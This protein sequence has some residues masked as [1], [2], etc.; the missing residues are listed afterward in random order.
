VSGW[1][2]APT[3]RQGLDSFSGREE[4]L[5][6]SRSS[7]RGPVTESTAR[8][9]RI[10][11]F[12]L[13]Q[14]REF[15]QASVLKV[16][17]RGEPLLKLVDAIGRRQQPAL[18]PIGLKPRR[19]TFRAMSMA[20][21]VELGCQANRR[22]QVLAIELA[23]C[24]ILDNDCPQLSNFGASV[25]SVGVDPHQVNRQRVDLGGQDRSRTN[26]F[27]GLDARRYNET[28]HTGRLGARRLEFALESRDLRREA[29]DGF[30]E[31][32]RFEP[33]PGGLGCLDRHLEFRG[34][35][36]PIRGNDRKVNGHALVSGRTA[37]AL[38][39][40]IGH[41]DGFRIEGNRHMKLSAIVNRS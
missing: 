23:P 26:R 18:V 10:V 9:K 20:E 39:G 17:I 14:V 19:V 5:L 38:F 12:F 32:Q 11:D 16:S 21:L 4:F 35:G 6:K 22:L 31:P 3:A 36:S 34:L 30:G 41:N 7:K 25:P 8:R 15:G 2:R 24:V 29:I 37:R 1:I 28:M 40:R 33:H 13:R 27:V